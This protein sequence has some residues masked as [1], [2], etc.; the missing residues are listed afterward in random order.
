MERFVAAGSY[1]PLLSRHGIADFPSVMDV[2]SGEV[3]KRKKNRSIAR[4]SLDEGGKRVYLYLKRHR[5]RLRDRFPFPFKPSPALAEWRGIERVRAAGIATMEPVAFGVRRR[6]GLEIASFTLTRE[7][8][9][10]ERLEDL[11]P[12]RYTPPL[13]P[14]RRKEKRD[15]IRSLSR[16]IRR[17]HRAGLHHRDLYLCHIF[18]QGR[19]PE[20]RLLLI[21]LQ[22]VGGRARRLNRWIVKDLAALDY[23]SPRGAVTRTDRLRFLLCYLGRGRLGRRGKRLARRVSRKAARIAAHDARIRGRCRP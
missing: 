16:L 6:F 13:S 21:D 3:L 18:L 12:R 20:G 22:R 23:S 9:E 8:E 5:P 2:S 1:L 15:L 11:V 10:G 4:L 19:P 14:R 17:L 7:V